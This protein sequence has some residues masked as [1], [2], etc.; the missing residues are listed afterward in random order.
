MPH[1]YDPSP[2]SSAGYLLNTGPKGFDWL[3]GHDEPLYHVR[4]EATI[5][6]SSGCSFLNKTITVVFHSRFLDIR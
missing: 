2:P 6:L 4:E 3:S 1:P 5:K